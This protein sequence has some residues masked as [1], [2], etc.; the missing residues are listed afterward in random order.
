LRSSDYERKAV[1]FTPRE[2]L[3]NLPLRR[4]GNKSRVDRFYSW[5][6]EEFPTADI[7]GGGGNTL[8]ALIVGGLLVVV[9]MFFVFG[10]FPRRL[11]WISA[12]KHRSDH[13]D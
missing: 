12:S 4:S 3:T 13:Q 8:L 2:G 7:S 9:V 6:K 5:E 11:R 1:E 10:G